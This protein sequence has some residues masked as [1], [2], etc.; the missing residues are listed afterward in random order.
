MQTKPGLLSVTEAFE[1]HRTRVLPQVMESWK[2][3]LSNIRPRAFMIDLEDV[4]ISASDFSA[5][6]TC[7]ELI[8][9]DDNKGR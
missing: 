5:Y 7:I 2:S 3:V 9:A 4:R 8:N 1:I 6:V